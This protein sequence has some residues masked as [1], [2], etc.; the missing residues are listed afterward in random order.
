MLLNNNAKLTSGVNLK[1]N[2]IRISQSVM[3]T[4]QLII[5][6]LWRIF[7]LRQSCPHDSWA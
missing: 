3:P 4:W 5:L 2:E 7:P 1:C 6:P